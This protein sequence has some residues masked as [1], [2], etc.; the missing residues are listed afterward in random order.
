MTPSNT[1]AASLALAGLAALPASAQ[2]PPDLPRLAIDPSDISVIG[3]SSG[4]YMATQLAVAW[5]ERFQGLGVLA[6]GPW[7]C[8]RGALRLALGQ[9]MTDRL[10]EPDLDEL[11]TRHAGYL[12]RD[13]VGQPEDLARLRLFIWHGGEDEVMAPGLSEALAEQFRGWLADPDDQLLLLKSE[14]VGHGWPIG[15]RAKPVPATELADC[16]V[17]EGSHLLACDLDIAGQALEF[18]HGELEPPADEASGRL[19]SFDQGEVADAKGLAD[20]G[21]LYIPEVCDEGGCGLTMALHGCGMGAEQIDDT[22]VRYNGLNEWADTNRRVVIYPQVETSMA[23]P[24]GCFDWWGY[25]ESTWQLD[26]LHDSRQG[27]QVSALM[28]MLERLEES[29]GD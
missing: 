4:G 20:S 24:Q 2:T 23:N 19:I 25:A 6:A 5:P 28:A 16:H 18:V 9:C 15:L 14:E 27:T 13:L 3:V 21:Y 17:G 7:S 22:F 11:A 12:R 29:P 8:A 1:L 26:P 10:G